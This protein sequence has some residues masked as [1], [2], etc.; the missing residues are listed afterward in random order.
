MSDEYT[1]A[2]DTLREKFQR[3]TLR[4]ADGVTTIAGGISFTGGRTEEGGAAVQQRN[5]YRIKIH[6]ETT[7]RLN[8]NELITVDEEPGRSL[9]ITSAPALS[10]LGLT[11]LYLAEEVR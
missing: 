9:R 4:R 5:A 11:V 2:R 7:V 6:G 1:P 3:R 8:H 10:G